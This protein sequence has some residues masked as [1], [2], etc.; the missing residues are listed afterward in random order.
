MSDNI[1][2]GLVISDRPQISVEELNGDLVITVVAIGADFMSVE[3]KEISIPMD[4]A[5]EVANA[6]LALTKV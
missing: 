3:H 4:C 5:E 1:R 2:G 6:I